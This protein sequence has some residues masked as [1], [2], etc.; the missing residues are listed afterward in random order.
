MATSKTTYRVV[1]PA[2]F[3]KMQGGSTPDGRTEAFNVIGGPLEWEEIAESTG[4]EANH[5][6]VRTRK[7]TKLLVQHYVYTP[8]PPKPKSPEDE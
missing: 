5:R 8:D 6:E 4:N 7:V 3:L 2:E 1:T